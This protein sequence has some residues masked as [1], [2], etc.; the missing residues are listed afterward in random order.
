LAHITLCTKGFSQPKHADT[1]LYLLETKSQFLGTPSTRHF[2][3][4][5]QPK[6]ALHHCTLAA[7]A[8]MAPNVAKTTYV[9]FAVVTCIRVE[10]VVR[11][12]YVTLSCIAQ[13]TTLIHLERP[14]YISFKSVPVCLKK[15]R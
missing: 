8:E 2:I 9:G 1:L 12:V 13:R 4:S 11:K 3:S 7:F 14:L 15:E 6:T 5:V 10:S